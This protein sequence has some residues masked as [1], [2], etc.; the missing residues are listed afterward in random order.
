VRRQPKHW[1]TATTMDLR[2]LACDSL[3]RRWPNG[4]LMY[5]ARTGNEFTRGFAS[6]WV[7]VASAGSQ[8]AD[9]IST[10]Q[11]T[12]GSAGPLPTEH[13]LRGGYK[14]GL[15]VSQGL[16]PPR[17][18]TAVMC[19]ARLQSQ[20]S[21]RSVWSCTESRPSALDDEWRHH[22]PWDAAATTCGP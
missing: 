12:R 1:L 13:H 21:H 17:L 6:A 22:R 11:A 9:R 16:T 10:T 5:V 14:S 18:P 8:K 2:S 7:D 19:I 3:P 4:R 20:R 15:Q